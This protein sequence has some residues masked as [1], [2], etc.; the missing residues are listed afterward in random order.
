MLTQM[1]IPLHERKY[2]DYHR[3]FYG[4]GFYNVAL[5]TCLQHLL[6]EVL[7]YKTNK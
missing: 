7:K 6:T 4:F 1:F 3:V 5:I 2:L